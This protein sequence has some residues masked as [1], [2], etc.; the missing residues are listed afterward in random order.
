MQLPQFILRNKISRS[1]PRRKLESHKGDYGRVLIIA[2][3]SGMT[4]AAVLASRGALRSG[5][6]LTYL[7]VPKDL[8]NI[9][10]SQTPE[11]ITLPIDKYKTVKP[12]VVA[13]GPG[14]GTSAKVKKILRS[15][16]L[17]KISLVIDADAI[18]IIAKKPNSLKKAK[19]NIIITPHPGEMARLLKRKIKDIQKNREA[20]ALETAKK[21]NCIVVLKG[22][23]TVIADPKGNSI[24]NP[25]GNPGMA[26]GG[27]G[28]VLTGMI[29]S[30]IGQGLSLFDAAIA[31]VFL[32]G[33]AGD[34]AAE[35]KGQRGMVASDLVEKIS[36]A[37]QKVT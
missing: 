18:N 15:L 29:A 36:N 16:L 37:L 13:I 24:I 33:L 22:N 7:A 1:L 25:T 26:S 30:F 11:V 17:R 5:S 32:H 12:N 14:L 2:G 8:V 27:V 34:L 19:A 31:G 9:I 20:L 21:Y 35:E 10:D 3:S 23:K 6:G 28:D 4:G